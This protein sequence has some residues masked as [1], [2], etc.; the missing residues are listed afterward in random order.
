[1]IILF[2]DGVSLIGQFGSTEGGGVKA[3]GELVLLGFLPKIIG[4]KEAL[5]LFSSSSE[6][7]DLRGNKGC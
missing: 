3:L 6:I 4:E 1:M 2:R 5:P 7:M